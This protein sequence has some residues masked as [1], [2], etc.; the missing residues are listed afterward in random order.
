MTQLLLLCQL[1]Y[2]VFLC[3]VDDAHP[4]KSKKLRRNGY[5]NKRGIKQDAV[6][7]SANFIMHYWGNKR[8]CDKIIVVRIISEQGRESERW[9]NQKFQ[10][11][12]L[13]NFHSSLSIVTVNTS[14]MRLAGHVDCGEPKNDYTIL[15]RKS[16]AQ[17]T[18]AEVK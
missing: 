17:M 15:N 11:A 13:H 12:V 9:I 5:I 14:R 7:C 4:W 18:K 3:C 16:T 8:D 1:I 10:N 6:L 2:N